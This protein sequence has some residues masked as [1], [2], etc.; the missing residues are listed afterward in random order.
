MEMMLAKARCNLWFWLGLF[1]D[2]VLVRPIPNAVWWLQV[3]GASLYQLAMGRSFL[4][5]ERYGFGYWLPVSA[6]DS[7]G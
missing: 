4:L 3:P 5:S 6:G 1:A 2:R 7:N